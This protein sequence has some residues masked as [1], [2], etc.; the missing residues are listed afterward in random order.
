MR[1]RAAGAFKRALPASLPALRAK[2]ARTSSA[3]TFAAQPLPP[4]PPLC[5]LALRRFDVDLAIPVV[6]QEPLV[7]V[8]V[9]TDVTARREIAPIELGLLEITVQRKRRRAARE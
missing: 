2:I 7:E 5:K 4:P 9:Q 6:C 3:G 8:R 1:P